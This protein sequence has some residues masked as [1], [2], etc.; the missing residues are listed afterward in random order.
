[1][2]QSR[3]TRQKEMIL[4]TI[5]SFKTFFNA[6]DVLDSIKSN[7]NSQKKIGIATIYRVLKNLKE[8]RKIYSYKCEGKTIYS[9]S[10][11]SHCHFNCTKTGRSFHFEI[12][13]LDFLKDKIPG[14]I[15]SIQIEVLGSCKED[16]CSTHCCD[17]K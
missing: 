3:N 4:H 6:Q 5:S 14:D 1:M 15:E 10:Q 12:D 17:K 11:K 16:M 7:T 13:S 8:S 2:V 9:N